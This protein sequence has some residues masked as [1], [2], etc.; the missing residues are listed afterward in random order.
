MKASRE[1]TKV[2]EAD[3][4]GRLDDDALTKVRAIADRGKACFRESERAQE[5]IY[6]Q[7]EAHRDA[8]CACM[9]PDCATEA[10]VRFDEATARLLGHGVP[11]PDVPRLRAVGD[12]ARECA[13][14]RTGG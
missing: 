5:A 7:V 13:A 6:T 12:S 10:A 9:T 8:I 2:L 11:K 1:V 4:T 3:M 14:E